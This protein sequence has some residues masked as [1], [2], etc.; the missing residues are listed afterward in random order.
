MTAAILNPSGKSRFQEIKGAIENH[1]SLLARPEYQLAEDFALLHFQRIMAHETDISENP[2]VTAMTNAWKL[3]G[4]NEFLNEFRNLAQK[5]LTP[6][7]PGINRVLNHDV[8]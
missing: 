6:Q 2:Q 4:V 7:A 8:K 3:A 1:H 5:P